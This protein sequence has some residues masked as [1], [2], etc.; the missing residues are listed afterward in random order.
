MIA[1][2]GDNCEYCYRFLA[3]KN[4]SFEA[5]EKVKELWV[6]LGLRVP[7]FPAQEMACNGCKPEN[8]CAYTDLCTCVYSKNYENCGLCDQYPCEL[9][10]IAFKKSDNLKKRAIK[11]C[12]TEEMALLNKAFFSKR[13]FFEHIHQEYERTQIHNRQFQE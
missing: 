4:G 9:I 11:V 12:T 5:L 2:C 13:E 6:R 10:K 3:T 1:L 7:D 8:R